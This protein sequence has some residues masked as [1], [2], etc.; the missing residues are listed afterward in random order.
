MKIATNTPASFDSLEHEFVQLGDGLEDADIVILML[1][2]NWGS[3]SIP[4]IDAITHWVSAYRAGVPCYIIGCEATI[5]DMNIKKYHHK[6]RDV[7]VLALCDEVLKRSDSIG[8]R[9]EIT[10]KYLTELGIDPSRLHLIYDANSPAENDK[11]LS[12]FLDR[13]K[14]PKNLMHFIKAFQLKPSSFYERPVS[15]S[16]NIVVSKPYV[17]SSAGSARLNADVQIDGVSQTLWCETSLEYKDYLLHERSDAFLSALLPLA[18]RS[19]KDIHF[20][21]PITEEF[22]HNIEEVLIPQLCAHDHRLYRPQIFAD[23]DSTVLEN[24]GAVATGMSCGVDSFYTASLYLDS[25]YHSM[26]LTHLYC[27]N[28]LY[29]NDNVIFERAATVAQEIGLPL[30]RTATNINEAL[31]LPH[32]YTHFFKMMFGVLALRKLFKTYYYST[33][34]DFSHFDL[35]KNSTQD[36]A[37]FEL[38]LLYVFNCRDF[39]LATGGAKSERLEKTRAISDLAPARKYLNVCLNPHNKINCGRCG[40][41]RRTLLM[42]DYLGKLA[43]FR[44][45]F[46]IDEYVADRFESFVYLSHQ[47]D[48]PVLAGVYAGFEAREL[49]LIRK[50]DEI[51][52]AA[53]EGDKIARARV[54]RCLNP[55]FK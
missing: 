37:V 43:N 20:E 54:N 29:G 45:V 18:M 22:L 19:E 8:V 24:G 49:N 16:K 42:L 17:T 15:Y 28:Y 40:K 11:R 2:K 1:E 30:I 38:L 47:K 46:N 39:Q 50:A 26:N 53:K 33:A 32:L 44:S 48:T 34:H 7:A 5:P 21:A 51:V 23:T 52:A 10:F 31:R 6:A 41:C 25:K 27:G 36:T 55:S 4:K 13:T 14:C 3:G 12:S 9:G 35:E